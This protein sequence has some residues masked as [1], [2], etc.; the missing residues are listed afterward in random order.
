MPGLRAWAKSSPHPL[1][2]LA[3]NSVYTVRGIEMPVIPGLHATLYAA[4]RSIGLATGWIVR[5]AWT[6]PMFKSQLASGA[7]RLRLDGRGLPLIIGPVRIRMG[8]DVRLSTQ[9]TISGRSSGPELAELTVGSNVDIGWQTTIA[10]GRRIS[11]GDDVRI[12][13]RAFLAGYPGHPL[14]P[15]ARAAGAPDT[16]DQVGDIVLEQGVWLATGVTVAAGV[17]IGAGTVVAA[18]SVVTKDLPPCVLAGGVPARVIRP[19]PSNTAT[20]GA[21]SPLAA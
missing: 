1:A 21:V 6:T 18:G 19:L 12:A 2:R 7:T 11:I 3:R 9:T 17:T 16:A 10:V 20:T 15:A 5:V 4:T 8:Q 14:D 13:G